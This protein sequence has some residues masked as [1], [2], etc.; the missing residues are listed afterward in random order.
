MKKLTILFAALCATMMAWGA[1]TVT[2]TVDQVATMH[3]WTDATAYQSFTLDDVISVTAK[4]SSDKTCTFP[5]G[6][7]TSSKWYMY[8]GD[9]NGEFT[10]SA[11]AEYIIKT[12]KI[13]Y[14]PQNSGILSFKSGFG[15]AAADQ[16]ASGSSITIDKQSATLYVGC[17]AASSS[18]TN[19][20]ARI[21]QFTVTYEL[22]EQSLI[23]EFRDPV[24][25]TLWNHS[26][27]A[28]TKLGTYG[29]WEM[30]G[31]R[32]TNPSNDMDKL[33]T[34]NTPGVGIGW[35]AN[36][37]MQTTAEGGVKALSFLWNQGATAKETDKTEKITVTV[38]DKTKDDTFTGTTTTNRPADRTF[39]FSPE[40]KSNATL[41]LEGV[42]GNRIVVGPITIVPYLRY[43]YTETQEVKIG[44]GTFDCSLQIDNTDGEGTITYSSDNTDVVSFANPA[45]P[46]ATLV[47][48]GEATITATWSEG[49]STSF[50]LKVITLP[51]P[52]V[53]FPDLTDNKKTVNLDAVPFTET[54]SVKVNDEEVSEPTITYESSNTEYATVDN[55]GE[56]TIIGEGATTITAKVAAC[57]TYAAAEASYVL[58]ISGSLLPETKTA[59]IAEINAAADAA[60]A[61][62]D[63]ASTYEAAKATQDQYKGEIDVTV[64][65]AI[66]NI[67]N[68][69]SKGAIDEELLQ[70]KTDI[71]QIKNEALAR[72][73]K[74]NELAQAKAEAV[75]EIQ[76]AGEG[77]QNTQMRRWIDAAIEDI[78]GV[79]TTTIEEVDRIKGEILDAL[80]FFKDGKAEGLEEG[81]AA[82]KAEALGTMGEPC[83]GCT[84]VEVTDGTTTVT[85]YNPTKVSYIKQE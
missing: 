82:G 64:S 13:T 46:E 38:G 53:T 5:N 45:E 35:V 57:Q 51:I 83:T 44:L 3:G 32:H 37:Y 84:A 11:A 42:N 39:M 36:P 72:I 6:Y 25:D 78:Q 81:K 77:I 60:K 71:N 29:E 66:Y 21:T 85:L 4:T 20:N 18:S 62:I 49:A 58:T 19:I 54:I 41:R 50:K 63:D 40:V 7:Y 31:I 76:A 69:T 55:N 2:K 16:I 52:V 80:R 56:V 24:G 47:G 79:G 9:S 26:T 43:T 10:I 48:V 15:I 28:T 27:A 33:K 67:N 70:A 22:V 12:I 73:I 8:Q 65:G 34:K 14:S 75:A 30:E 74:I 1:T 17:T 23:E 68:A 61:A 59:A